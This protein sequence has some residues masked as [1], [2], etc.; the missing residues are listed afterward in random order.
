[1]TDRGIGDDRR[2]P[3]TVVVG[4]ILVGACA[5][6][7]VFFGGLV[8]YYSAALGQGWYALSVTGLVL[9][10]IVGT[11]VLMRGAARRRRWVFPTVLLHPLLLLV[12]IG[13]PVFSGWFIAGAIVTAAVW[14]APTSIRW[15]VPESN[16]RMPTVVIVAVVSWVVTIT[17][18]SFVVYDWMSVTEAMRSPGS[19]PQI[20]AAATA[21]AFV[22]PN[23]LGIL[24]VLMRWKWVQWFAPLL[25]VLFSF[26]LAAG[27][28]GELFPSLAF[29]LLSALHVG[30][31]WLPVSTRWFR[32]PAEQSPGATA[33]AHPPRWRRQASRPAHGRRW[34]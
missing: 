1:M 28:S 3:A 9:A 23:L 2:M 11:V 6:W 14:C 7:W 18:W 34:P 27:W 16:P 32:A 26:V 13:L 29:V 10:M 20:E 33:S 31:L 5:G 15:F 21:L 19:D 4:L 24:A 12:M 8:A 30:L 22:V 25:L 17:V